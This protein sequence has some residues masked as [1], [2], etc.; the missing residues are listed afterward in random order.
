MATAV[1]SEAHAASPGGSVIVTNIVYD[2]T[3][4]EHMA[5]RFAGAAPEPLK[6][7]LDLTPDDSTVGYRCST[8]DGHPID[9]TEAT[10]EALLG[11]IRRVV[12]GA[13]SV[14]IDLGRRRRL[15][16]G[17][18]ALA[19]WLTASHCYWPGCNVPVNHCQTDH[20][21]PWRTPRAG[22]RGNGDRGDS[23]SDADSHGGHG[24]R[25]EPHNGAPLCGRHN[26]LKEHGYTVHRDTAGAIHI[27][28]PDGSE[29][30]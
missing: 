5:R 14:V 17:A 2:H 26:R 1:A 29:L 24:G 21:T 3:T 10:A 19:V 22:D 27:H 15:F 20:L 30:Q 8:L 25:T 28:R 13:D 11:H 18:A 9:R 7:G 6:V 23:D 4:F 12:V 16:T